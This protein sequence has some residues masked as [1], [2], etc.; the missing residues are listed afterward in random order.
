MSKLPFQ[1]NLKRLIII[2]SLVIFAMMM[3]DLNG[4]LNQLSRLSTQRDQIQAEVDGLAST[5]QALENEISYSSSDAAVEA[6][7]RQ[8]GHLARPGDQV[9]IPLPP[10]GITPTPVPIPTITVKKVD[11]WEIWEALFFGQ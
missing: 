2:G 8:S 5:K 7:A 3:M 9:I 4:R 10:P 11:N 6:W 1:I